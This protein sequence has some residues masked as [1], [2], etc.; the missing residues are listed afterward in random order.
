[1]DSRHSSAEGHTGGA[2]E[3]LYAVTRL[4]TRFS[5][6][7][8]DNFPCREAGKLMESAEVRFHCTKAKFA[9]SAGSRSRGVVGFSCACVHPAGR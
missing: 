7:S 5:N 4:L 2:A 3:L 6:S 1:M 9:P 8:P